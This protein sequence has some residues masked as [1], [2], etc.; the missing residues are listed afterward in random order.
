MH[1]HAISPELS[2]T[3]R[4]LRAAYAADRTGTR[5]GLFRALVSELRRAAAATR[6]YEQ[7]SSNGTARAQLG[8]GR[9]DVAR[10]V[11]EEYYG[12]E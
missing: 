11:F 10:Q 12:R 6:R 9:A 4:S 2:T 5:P 1:M 8:I 3:L 7:L